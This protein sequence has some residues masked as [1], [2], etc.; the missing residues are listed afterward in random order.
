M[1]D[2]GKSGLDGEESRTYRGTVVDASEVLGS[3]D[4]LSLVAEELAGEKPA[5]SASGL[6]LIH[7]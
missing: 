3:D 5:Y 1:R 2:R 7:I 4:Q 6:S